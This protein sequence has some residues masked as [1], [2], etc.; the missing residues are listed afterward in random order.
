MA[1]PVRSWVVWRICT[2]LL[3]EGSFR[4]SNGAPGASQPASRTLS[5]INPLLGQNE[6]SPLDVFLGLL[7]HRAPL[8]TWTVG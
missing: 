2:N 7:E 4:S 6:G 3:K 8:V 5:L 1:V